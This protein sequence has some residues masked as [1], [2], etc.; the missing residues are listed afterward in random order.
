MMYL[1]FIAALFVNVPLF[2]IG[3]IY[4]ITIGFFIK[5]WVQTFTDK[6]FKVWVWY[7]VNS[8]EPIML[9]NHYGI[10][11]L[12]TT[13]DDKPDWER[14]KTLNAFRR[15]L[16]FVSWNAFRNFA[17]NA[18]KALG[19]YFLAGGIPRGYFSSGIEY[20][21]KA[22]EGDAHPTTWRN[23]TIFGKAFITFPWNGGTHFRYSYTK[24]REWLYWFTSVLKFL[25]LRKTIKTKV[26]FMAGT[27]SDRFL[28][29][30][31]WVK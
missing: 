24:D 3:F 12:F 26:N 28:L 18:R 6:K 29:K 17:W 22:I 20:T 16:L 23:Q 8:D 30:Y 21:V 14:F 11:E 9:D 25:R 15:Y 10:Y 5:D 19:K 2:I 4:N 7:L 1:R 27:N 31:R 13:Q